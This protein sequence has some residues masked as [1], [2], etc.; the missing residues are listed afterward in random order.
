MAKVRLIIFCKAPVP[1]EVKTR[2]IPGVGA[3][4]AANIHARLATETIGDCIAVAEAL[5]DVQ[6][7]LWCSP[8]IDHAF[9][10]S[11]KAQLPLYP[12]EGGNLG[13]RMANACCELRSPV[14]LVGT[15]CPPV[16]QEYIIEAVAQLKSHSVV[17]APAEDGGYGLIGMQSPNALLF[18]N[19]HWSTARVLQ[20][21]LL[22][23]QEL[24]VEAYE[25]AK[26][27]DVDE[28][29]DLDRWLAGVEPS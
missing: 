23:C 4:S 15:D 6:A 27:W 18:E 11:F 19:I 17:I 8:N 9:F 14:V 1:G 2:L 20:Q 22:R 25:L 21:T 7:E 10:Q 5:P 12:Q 13:E 16:N 24:G 26:I 28:P 3:G 29:A